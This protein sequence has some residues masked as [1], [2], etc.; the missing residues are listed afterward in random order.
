MNRDSKPTKRQ[1]LILQRMHEGF[2]LCVWKGK[3]QKV[4]C[5]SRQSDG[6]RIP[7]SRSDLNNL[8]QKTLIREAPPT[9]ILVRMLRME[10]YKISEKGTKMLEKCYNRTRM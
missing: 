4:C 6:A 3:I 1:L 10:V 5:L 7:L 2:Q 9:S 8:L